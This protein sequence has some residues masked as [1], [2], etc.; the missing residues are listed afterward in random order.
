LIEKKVISLTNSV[1]NLKKLSQ[2]LLMEIKKEKYISSLMMN[3]DNFDKFTE[4]NLPELN[5]NLRIIARL[6]ENDKL[7]VRDYKFLEI[8]NSIFQTITRTIKNMMVDGYNRE[9]IIDYLLFLADQTISISNKLL[10]KDPSLVHYEASIS[11]DDLVDNIKQSILGLEKLKITY[12]SNDAIQ[13][14][15]DTII[16]TLNK[17]VVFLSK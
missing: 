2:L 9:D 6:Q 3:P 4:L 12:H 5:L 11:L 16:Q 15:L 1:F 13:S 7:Y 14:R 17:R 8:D 10:H